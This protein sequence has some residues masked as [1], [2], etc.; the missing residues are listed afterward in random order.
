MKPIIFEGTDIVFGLGQEEYIPLPGYK[1]PDGTFTTCM[2]LDEEELAQINQTKRLWL[3]V[4][5]FG[6]DLQPIRLSTLKPEEF[7][8]DVTPATPS[9]MELMRLIEGAEVSSSDP[10]K[11]LRRLSNRTQSKG[12]GIESFSEMLLLL[13]GA[14]KAEHPKMGVEDLIAQAY[15][16]LKS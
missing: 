6:N 11:L 16:S 2:E 3:S 10:F 15:K 1:A 5:T 9:I 13:L 4:L 12:F 14:F 7:G 8:L